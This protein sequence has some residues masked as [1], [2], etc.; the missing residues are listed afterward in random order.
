MSLDYELTFLPEGWRYHVGH[1]PHYYQRH[2]LPKFL[3]KRPFEAY[4]C[5]GGKL[6]TKGYIFESADGETASEAIRSA[7]KLGLAKADTQS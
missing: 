3:R 1:T 5:N 2:E 7:I 6:G 4:V